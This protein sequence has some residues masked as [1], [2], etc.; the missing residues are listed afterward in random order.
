MTNRRLEITLNFSH[1]Y[2]SVFFFKSWS[3]LFAHKTAAP[4]FKKAIDSDERKTAWYKSQL[5][6][7]GKSMHISENN[8]IVWIQGKFKGSD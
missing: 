4:S 8:Y 7:D 2:D 6:K 3:G 1:A 5:V